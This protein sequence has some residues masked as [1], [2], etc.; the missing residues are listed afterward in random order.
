MPP[1]CGK[2]KSNRDSYAYLS[3]KL[4]N[5]VIWDSNQP[6]TYFVS[7]PTLCWDHSRIDHHLSCSFVPSPQPLWDRWALEARHRAPWLQMR[8]RYIAVN[9]HCRGD[10]LQK[11]RVRCPLTRGHR[12]LQPCLL[13]GGAWDAKASFALDPNDSPAKDTHPNVTMI[14]MFLTSFFDL[15]AW[16]FQSASSNANIGT[17]GIVHIDLSPRRY[18]G[19][20]APR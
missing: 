17:K 5:C 9:M 12:S 11:L 16:R 18:H 4:E 1:C 8:I 13:G 14:K 2:A 19:Q 20:C 10:W 3:H 6:H 7:L 15:K